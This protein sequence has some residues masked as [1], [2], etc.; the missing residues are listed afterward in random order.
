[1]F[2]GVTLIGP[3]RCFVRAAGLSDLKCDTE[4]ICGQTTVSDTGKSLTPNVLCIIPATWLVSL[5]Y[6]AP[7]N[8]DSYSNHLWA[9]YTLKPSQLYVTHKVS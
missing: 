6:V 7:Q 8:L 2:V 1:M 9:E 5:L 3:R 4:W